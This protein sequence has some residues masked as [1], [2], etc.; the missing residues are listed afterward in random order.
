MVRTAVKDNGYALLWA[1]DEQRDN[2]AIVS[3]AV[4]HHGHFLEFAS[5]GWRADKQM[6][7][8][9]IRNSRV[10]SAFKYAASSLRNDYDFIPLAV[11]ECPDWEHD[12]ARVLGYILVDI[13]KQLNKVVR[14]FATLREARIFLNDSEPRYESFMEFLLC[15][16]S[17]KTVAKVEVDEEKPVTSLNFDKETSEKLHRHIAEYTG[18][19]LGE[20]LETMLL[21]KKVMPILEA[22]CHD[23]H[24]LYRRLWL[25][26]ATIPSAPWLRL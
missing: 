23:N 9:A 15:V 22:S 17:K 24:D 11:A 21:V 3:L 1:S 13:K 25:S 7:L 10:G 14:K 6:V 5:E 16:K 4:Q 12:V 26:G 19:P 8:L 20:R 2:Q 18:V